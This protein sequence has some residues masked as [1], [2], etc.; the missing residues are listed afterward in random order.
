MAGKETIGIVGAGRMGQAMTRHL[1]RHGYAVLAQ[2][3]EPK[4]VEAARALGAD[5]GRDPG[6]GRQELAR[7]SS[8]RSATTAR[9]KP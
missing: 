3:I 9:P 7:S 5:G 6:R 2:D 4:A 1:I 8:S